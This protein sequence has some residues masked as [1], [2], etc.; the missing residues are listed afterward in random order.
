MTRNKGMLGHDDLHLF[1]SMLKINP[2]CF[3]CLCQII[4]LSLFSRADKG[5]EEHAHK[6]AIDIVYLFACISVTHL[7]CLDAKINRRLNPATGPSTSAPRRGF[8]SARIIVANHA[9][10]QGSKSPWRRSSDDSGCSPDAQARDASHLQW[11]C[12]YCH[13]P[14]GS[15]AGCHAGPPLPLGKGGV[16]SAIPRSLDLFHN[17]DDD[18]SNNKKYHKW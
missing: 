4:Q 10:R 14:W 3:S 15:H 13:S 5:E 6:I 16:W 11:G 18:N 12:K 8:Q 9:T 7:H 17:D 2:L 1:V